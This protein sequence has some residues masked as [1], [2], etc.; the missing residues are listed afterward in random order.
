MPLSSVIVVVVVG[1][2]MLALGAVLGYFFAKTKLA[3]DRSAERDADQAALAQARETASADRAKAEAQI[4]GLRE[5]LAERGHII[6]EQKAAVEMAGRRFEQLRDELVT[7][8]KNAERL[9]AELKAKQDAFDEQKRQF[10]QMREQ[11]KDTFAG[12]SEK[13]LESNRSAF[14]SLAKERF[15]SQTKQ[16][17]GDLAK[18]QTEIEK[19]LAPMKTLLDAYQ[20]R[21]AEIEESRT[22]SYSDI[23]LQLGQVA[24]SHRSLDLQ[25][26]QLV[27]ALRD[28]GTRGQWGELKLKRLLELAGMTEHFDFNMQVNIVGEDGEQLRPDLVVNLP[29]ERNIVVDSKYSASDFLK[30]V[31]EEDHE[32]RVDHLQSF[33]GAVR[34]H[35]M[36]LSQKKYWSQ[37][38]HTPDYVV[39]FMPG[40]AMLYAAVDHAPGLVEE[41]MQKGVIL[42][43]PTTLLALLKTVAMGWREAAV[44]QNIEEV[45]KLG[46]EML[47]RIGVFTDHFARVGKNLDDAVQAYNKSVNSLETRLLVTSRKMKELG[48]ETSKTFDVPSPVDAITRKLPEL[49]E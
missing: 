27:Q 47:D 20:K 9:T 25:T 29:G 14:M 30:A 35:G 19:M 42:A 34:R 7:V 21:L 2:L 10:E 5:D 44:E 37:F 40:E 11:L 3:G 13:A 8:E 4:E 16:A 1:V 43:T 45:R 38:N 24:E 6:A 22:K 12:V 18:R 32:R 36:A 41:L 26:K 17:E 31:D 46:A 39:M 28:P 48:T 33:A 23:K 15:E 49:T